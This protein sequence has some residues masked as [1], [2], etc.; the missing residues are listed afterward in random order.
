M[1]TF[2]SFVKLFFSKQEVFGASKLRKSLKE[3]RVRV[4]CNELVKKQPLQDSGSGGNS[5]FHF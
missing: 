2:K 4:N 1:N 5:K 3:L